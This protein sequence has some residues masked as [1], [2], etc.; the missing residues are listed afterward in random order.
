MTTNS[1]IK[2]MIVDDS[3]VMRKILSDIISA[4]RQMEVV[5]T[6]ANGKIALQKIRSL[7]PDVITL[8]IEMPEMNGLELLTEL[9]REYPKIRVIMVSSHTERGASATLDALALGA[10]DYLCKPN[11]TTPGETVLN[12]FA[13]ELLPKLKAVRRHSTALLTEES[14]AHSPP[15]LGSV[16]GAASKAVLSPVGYMRKRQIEIVAIGVS[17]GGPMALGRVIPELPRD[18]NVPIVIVQHMPPMFTAMLAE[19]LDSQSEYRVV[20]AEAG[21]PVEPGTAYIAPGNY[22]LLLKQSGSEGIITALNQEPMENSCRPSVDVLLRSVASHY[23]DRSLTVILTGMGVDGMKGCGRIKQAGGS[24][25]VQDKDSSVVWG[26]PGA[27]A[28]AGYA[29]A[30]LPISEIASEIAARVYDSRKASVRI[31]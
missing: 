27:V 7:A 16:P 10:S 31:A 25:I 17:T 12:Q 26:M 6:A 13:E 18:L 14:E 11:G 1:Q 20:E 22:H 28:Q 29:D 9:Q 3:V 19:R 4:D 21:L 30:I 15:A 2:V 5:G 24:V 23:G 8:D